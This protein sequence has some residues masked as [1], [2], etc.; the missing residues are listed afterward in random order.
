MESN[1]SAGA[2]RVVD[3][4]L[5]LRGLLRAEPRTREQVFNRLSAY[6]AEELSETSR[7]RKLARD[8]QYLAR[9]GY[10]KEYD[11]LAKTYALAA[12]QIEGDWE[13]DELIALAA[14]RESFTAGAPYADVVQTLLKKIERGLVERQRK[15][16]TRKPA[17]TI[18]L[19]M[20][21]EPLEAA[22]I[23]R[24]LQ[25]A[26][27]AHQRVSFK[28]RP[29]DRP[30]VIPHPDDEPV[31][32]E[33]YDGHIYLWAYCYKMD[34]IFDFRVDMIVADS[35]RI[36]PKRAERR[37]QRKMI[38]FQYR[39]SPKL[40]ARGVTPRFPEIVSYEPQSD[41][42]MIVTA[43]DYSD[44]WIIREI[45]RYGEQAEIIGPDSLRAKMRR[46]VEQMA[47]LYG[48]VVVVAWS[49][50]RVVGKRRVGG[51]GTGR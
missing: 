5:A 29:L 46:V 22:A 20:G 4:L 14:L 39:L 27:D 40:A 7:D 1:G 38:D 15:I 25:E 11:H 26:I 45:L 30:Q 13:E 48:R 35:V 41:G 44:F 16:Y 24:K 18:K 12:P 37:W 49:G 36:L 17:L 47:E 34:R 8:L 9:W 10:R 42:S 28:Y 43:R 6:Y 2:Y 23:R 51:G 33:F 31:K 3:R 19:A 32:L 50:S 21:E